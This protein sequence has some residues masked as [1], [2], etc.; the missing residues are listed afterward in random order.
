MQAKYVLAGMNDLGWPDYIKL[1]RNKEKEKELADYLSLSLSVDL[2]SPYTI[3]C[4]NYATPPNTFVANVDFKATSPVI[5]I[6]R[7]SKFTP[8]DW[9]GLIENAD[10]LH[11]VDTVF[12]YLCELLSLKAKKMVLYKRDKHETKIRTKGL[13]SK[14]WEHSE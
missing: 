14:F 13:W 8:F 10:E 6:D 12:T 5:W 7:I 1:K 3:A 11:L 4:C 9:C 2:S